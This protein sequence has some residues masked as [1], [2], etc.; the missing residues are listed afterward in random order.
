MLKWLVVHRALRWALVGVLLS[1]LSND[2]F[3]GSF[4]PA[5]VMLAMPAWVI[6]A[7]ANLSVGLDFASP[8]AGW[9]VGRKG[10]FAC[11]TAAEL[12]EGTLLIAVWAWFLSVG[13][14]SWLL[15]ALSVFLLA[16][17]QLIDVAAEVFETDA[18]GDDDD[19]LISYVGVLTVAS[20]VLGLL[21]GRY[22]G[23]VLAVTSIEYLLLASGL[24]SLGAA[25]TR[26]VSR[27]EA[28]PAAED[29]LQAGAA[30]PAKKRARDASRRAKVQLLAVS[31][32]LGF[33]SAF[34]LPYTIRHWGQLHGTW[35]MTY[36]T[37]ASGVGTVLAAILFM[38]GATRL[39][40][41][42]FGRFS[43]AGAVVGL[44]IVAVSSDWLLL[45]V[46]IAVGGTSALARVSVTARQ[47]LMRGKNL[48][49]FAGRVRLKFAVCAAAGSWLGWFAIQHV[50][51]STLAGVTAIVFILV[52]PATGS[53]PQKKAVTG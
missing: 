33:A 38:I 51:P 3:E 21:V 19:A 5:T 4:V 20:A 44:G 34:W 14:N 31:A 28:A 43:L 40:M 8:L 50:T 10:A 16:T 48:A 37:L 26:F 30:V 36:I 7:R 27:K 22:L 25:A 41:L 2:L 49:A 11:L 1:V 18:A 17:G 32:A 52:L 6:A 46:A 35:T 12:L 42:P 39:G 13:A 45:G 23:A 29:F 15:F 47:L 24:L 53:F 9:L